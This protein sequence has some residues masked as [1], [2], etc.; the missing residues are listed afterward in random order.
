M[1]SV[2]DVHVLT[3]FPHMEGFSILNSVMPFFFFTNFLRPVERH[4]AHVKSCSCCS[5]RD[6]W[7]RGKYFYAAC[8]AS[9]LGGI[10]I[11]T[12]EREYPYTC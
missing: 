5:H 2:P 10:F 8:V 3:Y 12:H 9:R 1:G 7:S 6:S 4:N 11:H